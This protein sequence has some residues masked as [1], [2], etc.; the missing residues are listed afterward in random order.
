M[1]LHVEKTLKTTKK[2][3]KFAKKIPLVKFCYSQRTES[4]KQRAKSNE[5]R[6]TSKNEQTTSKK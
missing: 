2:T 5:R 3:Q 4:N 6:A 1:V